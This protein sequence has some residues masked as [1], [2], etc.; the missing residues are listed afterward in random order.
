MKTETATQYK[1]R[2]AVFFLKQL[3]ASQGK[4]D[5][6]NFYLSAFV[7]AALSVKDTMEREY[8]RRPREFDVW[9]KSV[10]DG[11]IGEEKR[12]DKLMYDV[13]QIAVHEGR[14][15]ARALYKVNFSE[16]DRQRLASNPLVGKL[17]ISLR[18]TQKNVGMVIQNPETGER[19]TF[20]SVSVPLLKRSVLQAP[21][22]DVVEICQRYVSLILIP[23]FNDCTQKFGNPPPR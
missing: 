21:D 5:T 7:S 16:S 18:G 11:R 19:T 14:L 12:L 13:R 6:F 4:F 10:E 1:L 8:K 9:F 17:L 23:F 3:K 22:K 15:N 2:E 20:E